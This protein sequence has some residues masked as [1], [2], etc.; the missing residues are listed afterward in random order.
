MIRGGKTNLVGN[1]P[2]DESNIQNGRI[3]AFNETA[4]VIEYIDPSSSSG[5]GDMLKSVYD[6][7]NNSIVDSADNIEWANITNKPAKFP[8]ENHDHN[9]LYYTKIETEN[10]KVF[11]DF[12]TMASNQVLPGT[13]Y[14]NLKGGSLI[15]QFYR[16]VPIP[17]GVTNFYKFTSTVIDRDGFVIIPSEI[18]VDVTNEKLIFFDLDDEECKITVFF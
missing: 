8:S 14:E 12:N 10:S 18:Y 3:L 5:S 9:D 11:I 15:N 2:V 17:S 4:D 16:E 13:E 6:Q 7:D 1:K